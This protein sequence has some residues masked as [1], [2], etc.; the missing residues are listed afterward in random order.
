LEDTLVAPKV[1]AMKRTW[2]WQMLQ[3]VHVELARFAVQLPIYR[4]YS[5]IDPDFHDWYAL[6]TPFPAYVVNEA[7]V[8]QAKQ[9]LGS[10]MA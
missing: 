5:F 3:V 9:R 1:N 8:K 2:H 6:V 4:S 7:R 10:T